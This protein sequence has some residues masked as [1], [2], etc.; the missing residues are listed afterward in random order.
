[1]RRFVVDKGTIVGDEAVIHGYL[2]RHMVK[3]LRLKPGA[4]VL[5]T[6]GEGGEYYGAI[7]SIDAM[8]L[9]ILIEKK[10]LA[11]A[12]DP[13]PRITLY[14]GLPKGDKLEYVLQKCTELGAAEIVPFTAARSVV[15]LRAERGA[16]RV[17]RWQKI[18]TE[19]A[20][21]SQQATVPRI[22]LADSLADVVQQSHHSVKLLLWEEEQATRLKETLA[23][24]S[25]PE[26]IAVLVGPEGGITPE[27]AA[28][29]VSAGFI[30]VS[31]G[32][33]ILRTETAGIV[34]VSILQFYWGDIG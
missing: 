29:A 2:H 14:Q 4:S 17:A 6:D 12:H 25:I 31:L 21:Q 22:S 13:G 24:Q 30:P 5:L 23:R 27:E 28:T 10:S 15:K 1:M 11:A 19:A 20:R 32:K 8:S 18:V 9:Q 16:D 7:Q 33:R 34:I 26:S 3:V